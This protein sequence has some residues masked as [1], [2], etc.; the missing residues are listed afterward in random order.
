MLTQVSQNEII[1][2]DTEQIR[3][4]LTEYEE[5]TWHRK[6]KKIKMHSLQIG[7]IP[8]RQFMDWVVIFG[9]TSPAEKLINLL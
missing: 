2:P 1:F 7:V 8:S 3:T 5:H 4:V 9:T 6:N